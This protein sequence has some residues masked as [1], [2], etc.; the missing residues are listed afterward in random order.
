VLILFGAGCAAK[1]RVVPEPLPPPPRGELTLESDDG[2]TSTVPAAPLPGAER[3]YPSQDPRNQVP[4]GAPEAFPGGA[5]AASPVPAP[6]PQAELPSPEAAAPST[7]AGEPDAGTP[8][9]A[10]DG[11]FAV[12]LFATGSRAAAD[13]RATQLARWFD[14]P[15]RVV[16]EGGMFKVRLG[17]FA[18]R[19]V[20]ESVRRHAFDLGFRDAFVV[21]RTGASAPGGR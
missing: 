3:I 20:A 19:G 6:L 17:P 1:S 18:D 7:E 15:P 9:I 21:E 12:Q 11:A 8:P 2:R 14:P 10:E 4:P 13:A 16:A 5:T